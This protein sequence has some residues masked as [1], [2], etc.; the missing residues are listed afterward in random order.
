MS[1]KL[2][3]CV[4]ASQ[5]TVSVWKHR[6]LAD[7]EVLRNDASGW[8]EFG[9]FLRVHRGVP[10]HVMVDTVKEDYRFETLPHTFGRDRHEMV[11][12]KLKQLYRNTPYVA[13]SKQGQVKAK[14]SE[15]QYLFSALTSP[16]LL[17]SWLKVI[18]V[19]QT[20]LAAIYL[21]PTVSELL[22]GRLSVVAGNILMIT[23]QAGGI[24]QSLFR[25]QKLRLSR[26]TPVESGSRVQHAKSHA[27]E[28]SNT[29]FYLDSLR[30]CPL[31]ESLT[32]LILDQ[33]GSL[34]E[35]PPLVTRADVLVFH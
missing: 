22:L 8:T 6:H 3:I 14:R 11:Q 1:A 20:P 28:I 10:A 21:L 27:E 33:D 31:D 18:E 24:R 26:L 4:S 35:L 25:D 32:V 34:S 29:R 9:H 23:H 17:D 12:R 2:L 7:L 30:I 13:A 16:D 15:D 19:N 5:A